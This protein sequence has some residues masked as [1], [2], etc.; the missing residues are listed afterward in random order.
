M[1]FVGTGVFVEGSVVAVAVA[2]MRAD[3][4][5]D[6]I[7]EYTISVTS[8]LFVF[9]YFLLLYEIEFQ[10]VLENH[11]LSAQLEK[12]QVTASFQ[13]QVHPPGALPICCW[14]FLL[15]KTRWLKRHPRS[16]ENLERSDDYTDNCRNDPESLNSGDFVLQE[17]DRQRYGHYR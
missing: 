6:N 17:N 14:R 15:Y 11:R 3:W 12:A 4:H 8:K 5:A 9:I 1:V 2:G 7:Q 13:H 16:N 10:F